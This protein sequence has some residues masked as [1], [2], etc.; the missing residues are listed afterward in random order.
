MMY[1]PR[2]WPR[3]RRRA[4]TS[5]LGFDESGSNVA[6][7]EDMPRF[8]NT[9]VIPQ[10]W[11]LATTSISSMPTLSK[12]PPFPTRFSSCLAWTVYSRNV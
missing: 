1:G 2:S 6:I 11:T 7:D 9:D 10:F 5:A 8:L 3:S 4:P 12:T